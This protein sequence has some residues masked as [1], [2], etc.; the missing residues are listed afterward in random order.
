VGLG[1]PERLRYF[2]SGLSCGGGAFLRIWLV[3]A[4]ALIAVS[5]AIAN[6][7]EIASPNSGHL[8]YREIH[9]EDI[10]AEANNSSV[11]RPRLNNRRS[12]DEPCIT[13]EDYNR[14]LREMFRVKDRLWKCRLQQHFVS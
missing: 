13:Q 12:V 9:A 8:Q 2:E 3:L 1:Y 14:M 10:L 5:I 4:A 7:S 6:A 11:E